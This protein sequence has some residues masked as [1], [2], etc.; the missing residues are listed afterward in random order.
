MRPD[1][2][3]SIRRGDKVAQ[4][5]ARSI[6]RQIRARQLKPGEQ[7][8]PE[9]QML[10]E[11]GVGRGSLRE[12]LRILEVHGLI[13]IKPGP[14]GGPIVGQAQPED[15][16]RM[17]TLFFQAGGM[18]FRELVE[19]RLIMEPVM[20]RL[21]AE[22]RDPALL[23]RLLTAAGVMPIDDEDEYLRVS[24]DFHRL[25]AEMSGNGIVN[26]F[27]QSLYGIFRDRVSGI[28]F[29]KPRRKEVVNA[30]AAIAKAIEQ[31]QPEEAEQLMYDHMVQYVAF[32]K[33]THP[34]LMDEVIDWR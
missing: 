9:A 20:A 17:A 22:R 31:G 30:H 10:Q 24:G 3:R 29:P 33:R 26:L 32:V 16:G 23:A 21:A 4:A 13:S 14:G 1:S 28:V 19:A 15:F 11:Y 8:P 7:L 18:T 5:V 12:A 25:V 27:S 6:V 34:T 2:H